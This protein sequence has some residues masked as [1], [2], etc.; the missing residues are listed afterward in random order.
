MTFHVIK[1]VDFLIKHFF[2]LNPDHGI[3]ENI[4]KLLKDKSL[5]TV[6]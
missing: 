1:N 3:N 2:A 6:R 5:K 4:F